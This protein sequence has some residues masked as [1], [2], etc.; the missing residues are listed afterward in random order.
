MRNW[1]RGGVGLGDLLVATHLGRSLL[2]HIDSDLLPPT[3]G[4]TD[5]TNQ[6]DTHIPMLSNDC[7]AGQKVN[8]TLRSGKG[9]AAAVNLMHALV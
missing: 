1:T 2:L 3:R 6:S 4:N 7:P 9:Q 8:N 5:A